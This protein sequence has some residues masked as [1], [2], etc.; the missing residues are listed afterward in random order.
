MH[1]GATNSGVQK[2]GEADFVNT[3]R[4]YQYRTKFLGNRSSCDSPMHSFLWKRLSRTLVVS[5]TCG[6]ALRQRADR[7][8]CHFP[9]DPLDGVSAAAALGAAAEVVIDLTHPRP[10]R[11]VRKRGPKLM[12]TEHI[13]RADDHDFVLADI[14]GQGR[15]E[16]N[17]NEAPTPSRH[18]PYELA[19]GHIS[20][21]CPPCLACYGVPHAPSPSASACQ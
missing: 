8:V 16:E 14:S 7:A 19:S 6:L 12:V 4:I 13:A 17:Q 2:R 5:A 1:R 10:L 3:R 9:H 11:S 20:A 18:E 21:A 15:N